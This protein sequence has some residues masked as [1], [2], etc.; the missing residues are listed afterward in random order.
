MTTIHQAAK[1]GKIEVIKELLKKGINIDSQ[2]QDKS[3]A[4]H[5]AVSFKQE[6]VVRYLVEN[7]ASVNCANARGLTPLHIAANLGN[8]II[9]VILLEA[10]AEPNAKDNSVCILQLNIREIYFQTNTFVAL[11]SHF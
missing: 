10:Q 6:D 4:L 9:L 7:G 11:F 3:T 2:A 8:E 1:D 5:Y